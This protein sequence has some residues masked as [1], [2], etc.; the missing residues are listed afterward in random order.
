MLNVLKRAGQGVLW[1]LTAGL[2]IVAA[3]FAGRS[4]L[5]QADDQVTNQPLP[6][7]VFEAKY[8]D[9]YSERRLF[10]GRV[11]P[12]QV[13]DVGFQIPG[14][15]A[16][17]DVAIGDRVEKGQPLASL[18]PVRIDLSRKEAAAQLA[19]AQALAE[20]AQNTEARVKA[21]LADGFATDQE[22]DNATADRKAADERVR[23]LR[24]RLSRIS[25]DATDAVLTAPFSGYVVARFVDS[26]ATVSAGQPV[27][28]INE[29]AA[30]EAKIGV[31][32]D[33]ARTLLP[34][35]TVDLLFGGTSVIGTI[36]GISDDIDP[37]TRSQ[38]VRLRIENGEAITPGG[39]IRMALNRQRDG[40][41][42]WVPLAS[43]QE[44]Y[45]GLWSVYIVAKEE[46]DDVI[47]R[48][49]VEIIALGDDR[50]YVTGT[51]DDGDRIV[52]TS[53][54]RFVPGQKVRVQRESTPGGQISSVASSALR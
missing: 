23:V 47:R 44:S 26:G 39:L 1:L 27:I 9:T 17:V 13:A 49:D 38:T 41:G 12:A 32:A 46:G 14:E 54:F 31:P 16:R 45:R 28:R 19:E 51:L 33:L 25:E 36:E 48:K 21:L 3:G 8:Q 37:L 30:F 29:D 2:I 7:L 4:M 40:R 6:V 22:F 34:G 5:A 42:V 24:R 18:D 35:E 50:A 53:T 43:L 10:A 11:A 52:T 20:R 15:V